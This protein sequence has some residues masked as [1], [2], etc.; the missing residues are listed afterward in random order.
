MNVKS[1]YDDPN[2]VIFTGQGSCHL[3]DSDAPYGVVDDLRATVEE[4]TGYSAPKQSM[5]FDLR[6]KRA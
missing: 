4:V 3:V 2:E 1:W 5:G 6:A